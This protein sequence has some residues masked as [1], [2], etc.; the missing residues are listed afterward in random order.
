MPTPPTIRWR[1]RRPALLAGAC[2]LAAG[3]VAAAPPVPAPTPLPPPAGRR[4][5]F[6]KDVR[7]L[8]AASCH[9][10]HG[11]KKQKGSY[12]LDRR[13]DAL[14]GGLIVPGRSA[15]SP[16]IRYVSGADPE[17]RMPPSGE[18]LT[19]AQVGILRAWIDQGARW[20]S[21]AGKSSDAETHW[22]YRPLVKPPVP[23][24]KT[25]DWVRN[26]VDA[27][28]LAKLEAKGLSPAPPADRRGLLR[29]VT[30]DL[31]GLPPTPEEADA[32]LADQSADA[33]ER[34]VDRLLA[35]P[36]YGERWARHW[37]DV[38]H[39]A[40]THGNDEDAPREHAW[41]YRDYLIGAFNDDKP[42]ARFAEEQIAGDVL[43]PGD[44]QA[45]V[46]TG[47][48]AAGPW[49]ESSQMGIKDDTVDK[50]VARYLDRDDMVTTAMA[51]FVSTTVGCARC[52][53]HKFDPVSQAE[54]YG[55]QAVFA[56][57][58]RT[59]RPYDSDPRVARERRTLLG[60]KKELDSGS[61]ALRARL[62]SPAAQAE[63]AAWEKET[64]ARKAAWTVLDA[65]SVTSAGGAVPE[66]LPDGSVRFGGTRP[67]VDTYTVAAATDL[68]GITAVRLEVLTDDRLPHGGPGRQDNGNLHLSEFRVEAAPK[69]GRAARGL[70]S[71]QNPTADFNQEGWTVAM[72]VD[73][74][75]ETAWGIYPEVGKPH[76]AVF[77][78][79]EPVGFDGGTALTF[80][81][82]QKHGGGHLIGRL[83]LAVARGP[84]AL[85]AAAVP[86]AITQILAVPHERRNDAQ[87]A[88]LA[89]FVLRRRLDAR[90]AALP[91]PQSVYA[92]ATDFP[93]N[94]NFKPARG[95]RPV[96]VL[97]RGDVNLPGPAA[98]PG[99]LACVPGPEPQFR[100]ADPAD[101]GARRAA[102]ARWVSD[103]RNVL[104]WRSAV[105]RAWHYHFGRGLVA[106]PGDFGR[107]GARPTHPELLDWLAVTF[108]D[109][110]GSLKRL[111]RLLVTSAAYRQSSRH[112]PE[113]AKHDADNL[114]LWR[115]NRHRLDAEEVRDAVLAVS[116][117]LD[118]TTGG[119]SAKQFVQKPGVHVTPVV[120]Y[121]AFDVDSPAS[122]RRGVYR[123]VF[124]TLP[125][126][127]LE[128]LDCPDGSQLTPVRPASVTALQA[129]ALLNDRFLVR[130]C[131]HFA[132]RVAK[133]GDLPAQVRA[134]YRLALGR[135]PVDVECAA[136]AAYAG[137]HGMANACRLLLNCNEF[138][139]VP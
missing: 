70:I 83:R 19:A 112:D 62:L 107:M 33:Y 130:Q 72:A 36:R 25:A 84:A 64:A 51:T 85:R 40:E 66:K 59:D 120:D 98:V 111:H 108:R 134:A 18:P 95:C 106:T 32:F 97:R 57:V 102:L 60:E 63:A 2:L 27:F 113:A 23:A 14:R 48:L 1:V 124:R 86:E 58:D 126:P 21:A 103:P 131:E 81:L 43:Y 121:S 137:R 93:S 5:D 34:V 80:T 75:P 119:P 116:G 49:D 46:A 96:H 56:G 133:A 90:L 17:L 24:V 13:E 35:S 37:M 26:P 128:T 127:F 76:S 6:A 67:A 31:T 47:F 53:D 110:G 118:L 115:A 139:F 41:P 104:T 10:C 99:A 52:H 69:S 11:E 22:A 89:R 29:R 20:E 77:E 7:P 12:R 79:K 42:Y 54:Y 30:F 28:V 65:A 55:L 122:Y 39:Y 125:D 45:T 138:L 74:K 3:A 68:K 123:F 15:D 9:R 88:D 105:N 109:G 101:E 87:K 91:A 114:L 82:E 38:A 100:L 16:L 44:P 8:L 135:P 136:L 92:V 78:F 61:D 50:Q 129:L 117:K 71:L 73:G 4:I 132:A 94:G